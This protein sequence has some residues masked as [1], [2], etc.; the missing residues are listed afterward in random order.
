MPTTLEI[1][2]R[3]EQEERIVI[4]EQRQY[5]EQRMLETIEENKKNDKRN[6]N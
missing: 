6:G 1:I 2:Q 3:N 4:A 5:F